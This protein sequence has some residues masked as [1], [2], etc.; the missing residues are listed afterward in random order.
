MRWTRK[1]ETTE[2]YCAVH[3]YQCELQGHSGDPW[4]LDVS[5]NLHPG[6]WICPQAVNE[7]AQFEIEAEE[8]IDE[9]EH[10]PAGLEL[11]SDERTIL[12]DAL[13]DDEYDDIHQKVQVHG[14]EELTLEEIDGCTYALEE[15]QDELPDE[16]EQLFVKLAD[17]WE[18]KCNE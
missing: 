2:M 7:I 3:N 15:H 17:F 6:A 13:D 8:K 10:S 14:A 9:N 11:T 16:S 5:P 4:V 1:S 18:A 12:L